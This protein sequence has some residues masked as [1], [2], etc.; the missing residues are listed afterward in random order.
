M[1]ISRSLTLVLCAAATVAAAVGPGQALAADRPPAGDAV[2]VTPVAPLP[3]EGVGLLVPGCAGT[4]GG[5]AVSPAFTQPVRLTPNVAGTGLVGEADIER[6]AR[7]GEHDVQVT[8]GRPEG[9]LH[10]TVS[11]GDGTRDAAQDGAG[12][13]RAP[14]SD[15]DPGAE[16][17]PGPTGETSTSPDAVRPFGEPGERGEPGRGAGRET[18]G[19]E[20]DHGAGDRCGPEHR[21]PEQ[22]RPAPPEQPARPEKPERPGQAEHPGRS[23]DPTS[24]ER[25]ERPDEPG[26]PE[27]PG[28]EGAERCHG[29]GGGEHRSGP[30][31]PVR[32]GGG[33]TA[34]LAT[35]PA[36]PAVSWGD[37][38]PAGLVLLT[39]AGATAGVR[40]LRSRTRAG[41]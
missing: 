25:P 28:D 34:D 22:H 27:R 20:R 21:K 23:E 26:H 41:R 14:R 12:G 40:W 16:S 33:G 15:P 11:V 18:D 13:G 6:D 4:T 1:G 31:G 35:A 39:G 37:T 30:T 17:S 29:D 3:G 9:A 8:C 19:A 24:P 7:V 2:L 5:T 36:D 38:I 32:A 10:G